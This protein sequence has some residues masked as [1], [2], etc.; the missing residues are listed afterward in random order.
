MRPSGKTCERHDNFMQTAANDSRNELACNETPVSPQVIVH[1]G[2]DRDRMMV[3]EGY[4]ARVD[5]SANC[6]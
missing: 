2:G 1:R 3:Y 4:I 6:I 5:D